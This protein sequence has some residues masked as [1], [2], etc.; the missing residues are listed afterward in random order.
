MMR[1]F[2]SAAFLCVCGG[3][4]ACGGGSGGSGPPGN[5]R[6]LTGAITFDKVTST[7]AGLNYAAIVQRPVRGADVAVVEAANTANV[8][9]TA[10]TGNDGHYSVTWPL[11][12]PASVKV[13]LFA[14]TASPKIFV[15]DNTSGG[16]IYAIR[17]NGDMLFYKHTGTATGSADWPIQ[18]KK[19]G[20]GW[21]FR[22]V[23]AGQ[24]FPREHGSRARGRVRRRPSLR[25]SV[26]FRP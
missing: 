4:A 22:Q 5:V 24:I 13:V 6:S 19:I 1:A 7:A 11:S 12:G 20:N 9:G 23:F 14:R 25:G 3:I 16:A 15:E 10:V 26:V 18:A 21:N 17:D 2:S 8:L